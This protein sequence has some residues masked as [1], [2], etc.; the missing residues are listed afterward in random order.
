MKYEKAVCP[1]FAKKNKNLRDLNL[2]ICL[3]FLVGNVQTISLKLMDCH[4][5]PLPNGENKFKKAS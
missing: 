4:N 5:R 3:L 2:Q 1:K